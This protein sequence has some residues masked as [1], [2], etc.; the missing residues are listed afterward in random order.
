MDCGILLHGRLRRCYQVD[1]TRDLVTG[2][3]FQCQ[4]VSRFDPGAAYTI[5][6]VAPA[7]T[8]VA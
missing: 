4:C 1:D 8:F 7:A 3:L 6:I 2:E 5:I